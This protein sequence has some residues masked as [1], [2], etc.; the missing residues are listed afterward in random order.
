LS[1]STQLSGLT[2]PERGE[3]DFSAIVG[4]FADEY[5]AL[6]EIVAAFTSED[7]LAPSGCQGWINAD[8]LFHMLLD[9]QRALVTFNTPA[10]GEADKDFVTYWQGFVAS[11]EGSR[12]H[13]RFVRISAA[14]HQDPLQICKRWVE[15]SDAAIRSCRNSKLDLVATQGHVLTLAD[16]VATLV[17]EAVIH[18]LDLVENLEG[19]PGP[20]HSAV[21]VTTVT[22]DGLLGRARPP[23]WD[24]KVYM[25]KATG[26]QPLDEDDRVELG[27]TAG[28]IPVFS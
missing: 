6:N 9:A 25:L 4:A 21:S 19:T 20:P 13:A 10:T 2:I 7:L 14:A 16:F 18:H 15:T 28:S 5:G 26:R 8:L 3:L 1:L 23:H 12:A 22:L 24:D 11:D 17:V 27:A